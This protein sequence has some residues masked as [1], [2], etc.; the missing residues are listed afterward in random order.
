[1]TLKPTY[2]CLT[3][4]ALADKPSECCNG[5]KMV[6]LDK[7][8]YDQAQLFSESGETRAEHL[9]YTLK[10]QAESAADKMK[11]AR[12]KA[13]E[14]EA[15]AATANR[16]LLDAFRL[17]TDLVGPDGEQPTATMAEVKELVEALPD[18]PDDAEKAEVAEVLGDDE[19]IYA[20]DVTDE[21]PAGCTFVEGDDPV[22]V[23][24]RCEECPMP[25]LAEQPA[26]DAPAPEGFS[27][28]APAEDAGEAE[29]VEENGPAG[30]ILYPTEIGVGLAKVRDGGTWT[31]VIEGVRFIAYMK[32]GLLQLEVQGETPDLAKQD[33]AAFFAQAELAF[34][35][36]ME[37]AANSVYVEAKS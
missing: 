12:I 30:H 20:T 35:A 16:T 18:E 22:A 28:E 5:D 2:I 9:L 34:D 26:E 14:A 8:V 31:Q 36:A 33:A 11:K 10:A 6:T 3:C 4:G 15:E 24:E 23:A 37:T 19:C 7:A 25:E 13:N 29:V 1:M 27:M 32:D 21:T 17:L